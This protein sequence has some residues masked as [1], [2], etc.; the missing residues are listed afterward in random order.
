MMFPSRFERNRYPI[1]ECNSDPGQ[2]DTGFNRKMVG[3]QHVHFM[4]NGFV[5]EP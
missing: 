5:Y 3:K 2:K 1:L 4:V